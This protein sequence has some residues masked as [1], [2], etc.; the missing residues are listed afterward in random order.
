MEGISFK[1]TAIINYIYCKHLNCADTTR[2]RSQ[3]M[4][5]DRAN[6]MLKT[7]IKC[8][9]LDQHVVV[10]GRSRNSP[11]WKRTSIALVVVVR[12]A[13]NTGHAISY[14]DPDSPKDVQNAE[15]YT[16]KTMGHEVRDFLLESVQVQL[17]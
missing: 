6:R 14:F 1:D 3:R 16:L 17:K 4:D 5:A 8:I 11:A 13:G 2:E 9:V 7:T 10:I 12:R 15:E